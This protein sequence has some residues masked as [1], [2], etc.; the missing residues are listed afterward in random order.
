MQVAGTQYILDS[1]MA[2][3]RDHPDRKFVY[4]E[5]VRPQRCHALYPE[6]Q[7]EDPVLQFSNVAAASPV[8][9]GIA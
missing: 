5:M 7:V 1:V 6:L 2:S 4:G 3:L 9:S 8:P